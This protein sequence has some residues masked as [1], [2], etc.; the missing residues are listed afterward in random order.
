MEN[1]EL[2]RHLYDEET[3]LPLKEFLGEDAERRAAYEV[4]V[5]TRDLVAA[6]PVSLP[7]PSAID[8]VVGMAAKRSAGRQA[9]AAGPMRLIHVMRP[10]TWAAAACLIAV[11]GYWVG[12]TSVDEVVSAS[13]RAWLEAGTPGLQK[14][15]ASESPGVMPPVADRHAASAF[16]P[17]LDQKPS[18]PSAAPPVVDRSVSSA[19]APPLDQAHSAAA[20]V[21]MDERQTVAGRMK[22]AAAPTRATLPAPSR[23]AAG[24]V[25]PRMARVGDVGWE[26]VEDLFII[27]SRVLSLEEALT[28]VEWEQAVPLGALQAGGARPYTGAAASEDTSKRPSPQIP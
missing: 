27:Q 13:E 10:I 21:P 1:L 2:I 6:R 22:G 19:F 11:A 12:R 3:D 8:A 14:N 23:S 28:G 18:V 16:D 4:L 24:T 20:E 5:E 15:E 7:D 9:S 17:S 25:L 26:G